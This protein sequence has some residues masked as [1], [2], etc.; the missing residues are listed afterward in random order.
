MTIDK[1]QKAV[2]TA[3]IA[4]IISATLTLIASMLAVA[5]H[6]FGGQIS[7]WMFLDAF[8]IYLLA[9]GLYKKSRICA[10]VMF[11]YWITLQIINFIQQETAAGAPIAIL[12]GYFFLMGVIGTF[13]YHKL[14]KTKP[15]PQTTNH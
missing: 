14:V 15:Q 6:T 5:G 13:T 1:A 3:Y 8:L 2:R 7:A 12:F 4:A 11:L 10:C 9:L